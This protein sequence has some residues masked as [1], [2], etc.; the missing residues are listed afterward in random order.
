MKQN[1]TNFDTLR[2]YTDPST[3]RITLEVDDLEFLKDP[4]HRYGWIKRHFLSQWLKWALNHSDDIV[5]R[6][7]TTAFDIHRFYYIPSNRITV[8]SCKVQ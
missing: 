1:M 7:A 6:D 3:G 5:A 8:R 4:S 2:R